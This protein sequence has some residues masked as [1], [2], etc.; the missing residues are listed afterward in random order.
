MKPRKMN[1]MKRIPIPVSITFA[2]SFCTALIL[3]QSG[4]KDNPVDVQTKNPREYTWTIDTIAYPGSSQMTMYDIW[5]SDPGNV[6]VCGYNMMGGD[7]AI[8]HYD[9]HQWK[10][11]HLPANNLNNFWGIRGFAAND[12]WVAGAKLYINPKGQ[13]SLDSA[14]VLHYNGTSW[15]EML[16]SHMGTRGLKSVWGSSSRNLFFGSRDGKVIRFDGSRWSIDTLYLGL[17]MKAIGGDETKLFAM[18]NTWRGAQDDSVMCFTLTPTGWR[19]LDMQLWNQFAFSPRFGAA[20]I[21]C[22]LSGVYYTA[23]FSSIFR[24]QADAWVK[25]H[26][27]PFAIDGL[28]GT[29]EMNMFAVGWRNGP[30]MYQW[31]GTD[32]QEIALPSSFQASDMELFDVWTDGREAF[33]VGNNGGV[34]CVLHG[35]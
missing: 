13:T 17:S 30:S 23:A 4:C 34:S 26:D 10:P 3:F 6:Y 18:G 33:V 12:I 15:S 27:F 35:K 31:D 20:L 28:S 5:G 8:Y 7:G 24:W 21:Y 1:S 19:M 2:I 16:Q 9:G 25:V 29:S 32:W 22:P 14:A 11:V